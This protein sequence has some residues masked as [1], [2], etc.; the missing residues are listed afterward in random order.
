MFT[1][2]VKSRENSFDFASC[3]RKYGL[4]LMW[5]ISQTKRLKGSHTQQPVLSCL[6]HFRRNQL[7]LACP[8]YT[9]GNLFSA[10]ARK[11]V[12]TTRTPSCVQAAFIIVAT[13]GLVAVNP[14]S[15]NSSVPRHSTI[16]LSEAAELGRRAR[17]KQVTEQQSDC[18]ICGLCSWNKEARGLHLVCPMRAKYFVSAK[19]AH[20][21]PA[22][23]AALSIALPASDSQKLSV[24]SEV[25][26][27]SKFDLQNWVVFLGASL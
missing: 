8:L 5:M 22:T 6:L 23:Q 12:Q 15:E 17:N 21:F 24:A 26:V 11:N 20:H 1:T 4:D 14:A 3:N 10:L 16:G 13:P 25:E 18:F 9:V 27:V 2:R 19:T 7:I